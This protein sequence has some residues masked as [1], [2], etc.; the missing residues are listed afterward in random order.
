MITDKDIKDVIDAFCIPEEIKGELREKIPEIRNELNA[1]IY[2][3]SVRCRNDLEVRILNYAKR[4]ISGKPPKDIT[5][6]ERYPICPVRKDGQCQLLG[7]RCDTK[8]EEACGT[9][10]DV[11]RIG[12]YAGYREAVQNHHDALMTLIKKRDEKAEK[13]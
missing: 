9:S 1:R 7:G 3:F 5:N 2:N 4:R 10:R 8:D 11:Y 6:I 12:Y 13:L